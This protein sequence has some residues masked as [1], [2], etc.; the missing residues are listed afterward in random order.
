[1]WMPDRNRYL[2]EL[3]EA[4]EA[5][6]SQRRTAVIALLDDLQRIAAAPPR[7]EHGKAQ[8]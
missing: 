2:A 7:A 6:L 3:G 5:K 1:M 4:E 8:G